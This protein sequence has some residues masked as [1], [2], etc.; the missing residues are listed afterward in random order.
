MSI[1]E[2]LRALEDWQQALAR[3]FLAPPTPTPQQTKMPGQLANE[4]TTKEKDAQ[5]DTLMSKF[6]P[7]QREH[8]VI[9]NGNIYLNKYLQHGWDEINDQATALGFHWV[10]AG[11]DSHW[12]R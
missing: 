7:D 3:T 4:N 5:Q 11:K 6:L 9:K 10:K 12:S 8:L 2:R 1:E